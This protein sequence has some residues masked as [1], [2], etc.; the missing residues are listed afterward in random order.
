VTEEMTSAKSGKTFHKSASSMMV[1]EMFLSTVN[2]M[3]FYYNM[4]QY[5]LITGAA[6]I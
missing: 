3:Y 6:C 1:I 5:V 4:Q 2:V